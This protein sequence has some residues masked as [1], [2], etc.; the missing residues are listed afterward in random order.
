MD[1]RLKKQKVKI[2]AEIIQIR[3]ERRIIITKVTVL[4]LILNLTLNL[5]LQSKS[6]FFKKSDFDSKGLIK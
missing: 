6:Q 1:L 3:K 5:N 2:L 4:N